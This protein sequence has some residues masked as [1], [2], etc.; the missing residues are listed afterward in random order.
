MK[1]D[2]HVMP[3]GEK[4]LVLSAEE[5]DAS[6]GSQYDAELYARRVA[7]EQ[8]TEFFLHGEDGRV[9]KRDSYDR[10]SPVSSA[11]SARQS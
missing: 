8:K 9:R 3:D 7:R 11:N 6:F 1:R 4:W 5:N 10:S 2:V